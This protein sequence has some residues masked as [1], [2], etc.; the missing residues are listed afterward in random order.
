MNDTYHLEIIELPEAPFVKVYESTLIDVKNGEL[1]AQAMAL[2]TFMRGLRQW[3][4]RIHSKKWSFYSTDLSNRLKMNRKT[5]TKYINELLDT[6][7]IVRQKSKGEDGRYMGWTYSI[8]PMRLDRFVSLMEG[9]DNNVIDF[10]KW[11]ETRSL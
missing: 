7:Y 11:K 5:V 4:E 2:H 10:S 1:S 9:K 6:S 8:Y 3:Y